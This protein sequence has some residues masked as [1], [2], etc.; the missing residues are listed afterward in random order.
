ME[1]Y[2][3]SCGQIFETPELYLEH[4]KNKIRKQNAEIIAEEEGVLEYYNEIGI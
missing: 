3:C 1:H 4:L 2:S